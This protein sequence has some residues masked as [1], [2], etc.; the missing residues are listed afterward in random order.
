VIASR[1]D[2]AAAQDRHI[3]QM[4]ENYTPMRPIEIPPEFIE[5]LGAVEI[6]ASVARLN[7]EAN[8]SIGMQYAVRRICALTRYLEGA[9]GDLLQIAAEKAPETA[10]EPQQEAVEDEWI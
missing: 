10:P 2:A 1:E 4:T 7:A 8:D 6:T 9:I 3:A 5:A